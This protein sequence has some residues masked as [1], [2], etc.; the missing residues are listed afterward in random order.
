MKIPAEFQHRLFQ[1]ISAELVRIDGPQTPIEL[2]WSCGQFTRRWFGIDGV[3][4]LM[5]W[6]FGRELIS[7]AERLGKSV[8]EFYYNQK[9]G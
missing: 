6:T 9:E 2:A 4:E 7:W 8:G 3:N 1:F 5:Q